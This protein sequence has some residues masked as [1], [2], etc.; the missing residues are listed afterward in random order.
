MKTISIFLTIGVSVI[1]LAGCVLPQDENKTSEQGKGDWLMEEFA[2]AN[3][4]TQKEAQTFFQEKYGVKG[5][6][7]VVKNLP[8]RTNTFEEEKKI[9][10]GGS[11]ESIQ[12]ATGENLAQPDF[13][14]TFETSGKTAWIQ[15]TGEEKRVIGV[16]STPADQ[17]AILE[18]G[19][20]EFE[21]HLIV[22]SAWGV[23][24]YQGVELYAEVNPDAPMRIEIM[25]SEFLLG[26]TFPVFDV[27]WVKRVRVNGVITEKM[28]AGTYV[29]TI[30]MRNPTIEKQAEWYA[31]HTTRYVNGENALVDSRGL[32]TLTLHVKEDVE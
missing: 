30:K 5:W 16:F 32:A 1:L 11:G 29:I 3:N 2:A 31:I 26:P 13:Y 9:W 20:R 22:G 14:E 28:G 7:D 27:N 18:E 17:E 6:A 23:T 12:N 24:E 21:T 25:E 4:V 8:E 15:A 19:S 10:K